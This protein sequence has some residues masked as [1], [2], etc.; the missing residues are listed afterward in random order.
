MSGNIAKAALT[1]LLA[2]STVSALED[3]KVYFK[4]DLPSNKWVKLEDGSDFMPANHDPKLIAYMQKYAQEQKKEKEDFQKQRRAYNGYNYNEAGAYYDANAEYN[5]YVDQNYGDNQAEY[6]NAQD[7]AQYDN[8]QDNAQYDNA[9]DNGNG[10]F[11]GNADGTTNT[12]DHYRDHFLDGSETF[13]PEGAQAWRLLG[14]YI[15]CY[16]IEQGYKDRKLNS[17]SQEEGCDNGACLR[18]LLWA[19]VSADGRTRGG[20]CV[21]LLSISSIVCI[22]FFCL[23]VC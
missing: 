23:S 17:H 15:D 3:Q 5:N 9:Q 10:Y 16:Q 7:N 8:A 2:A 20:L 6:Q 19:A 21:S 18:Y 11:Y 12:N 4:E 13:W 14:Y 1:A 22:S